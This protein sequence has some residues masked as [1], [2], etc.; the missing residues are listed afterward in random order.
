MTTI[1]S[2]PRNNITQ[3]LNRQVMSNKLDKSSSSKFASTID[4]VGVDNTAK[5]FIK[6]PSQTSLADKL[7]DEMACQ[8]LPESF[9]NAAL[10]EKGEAIRN[11]LGIIY[12][13]AESQDKATFAK[14]FN[15][16]AKENN[17]FNKERKLSSELSFLFSKYG[18]NALDRHV[19]DYTQYCREAWEHHHTGFDKNTTDEDIF[20][21][22]VIACH[23]I[24][25]ERIGRL[26]KPDQTWTSVYA[27]G[28]CFKNTCAALSKALKH[29]DAQPVPEL[30]AKNGIQT[31]S[32]LAPETHQPERANSVNPGISIPAGNGHGPITVHG[33]TAYGGTAYGGKGISTVNG[34]G[35]PAS[36]ADFGIAL[37]N[38]PNE[39]LSNDKARLVEKFMD[40]YLGRA[41][42]GG[43]DK[44]RDHVDSVVQS[45]S[46]QTVYTDTLI[47]SRVEEFVSIPA[48][49]VA[50]VIDSPPQQSLE[51]IETTIAPSTIA[52]TEKNGHVVQSSQSM[53]LAP[54]DTAKNLQ[55]AATQVA[56][57]LSSLLTETDP[58]QQSQSIH[59][60]K[61][62][63]LTDGAYSELKQGLQPVIAQSESAKR[64]TSTN[65][66]V[67]QLVRKFET[68][69]AEHQM[70]N[71]SAA[72]RSSQG[73]VNTVNS[74][75]SS[76]ATNT[77]KAGFQP[78]KHTSNKFK[79]DVNANQKPV[80]T[81]SRT[82]DPFSRHSTDLKNPS[83]SFNQKQEEE[84]EKSVLNSDSVS[85]L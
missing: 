52:M 38:T 27:S 48:P 59:Q 49:Q 54:T 22:G 50:T 63:E 55:Q 83:H 66:R 24:L 78:L 16:V 82:I 15:E 11:M 25:K 29:H 30:S 72:N 26:S 28:V 53:P 37:L 75:L 45:P 8:G 79:F 71:E 51:Y 64:A 39:Q 69:N 12:K 3:V 1:I 44:F 60:H 76:R 18:Q 7:F 47:A 23:D 46:S 32:P 2:V 67:Q 80:Y 77:E 34:N 4:S 13:D 56:Q 20:S 21:L 19:A 43:Q 74:T 10:N 85:S 41:Q 5:V 73:T 9:R 62:S 65:H 61:P 36:V 40:L 35:S 33:S 81:T 42:N 70:R 68:L 17:N 57:A 14:V 84:S 6:L 31:D 58:L